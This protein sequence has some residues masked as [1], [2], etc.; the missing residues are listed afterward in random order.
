MSVINPTCPTGCSDYLPVVDFDPCD[1]A[2]VFGEIEKIYLASQDAAIVANWTTATDWLLRISNT[3]VASTDTIRE[4]T[5]SA[6]MPAGVNEM[7]EISMRRKVYTPSTFTINIDIDDNTDLNY[8]FM[9]NMECNTTMRLWFADQT[10]LYGGEGGVLATISMKEVILRGNKSIKKL[11]GTATWE[12][13]FSPE[14]TA[15]PL[16]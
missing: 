14:R 7:V 3:D 5:V 16:V 4:L 10:H 13:K 12:S 11:V 8:E 1:P 9:R 2:V 15:N 6:D